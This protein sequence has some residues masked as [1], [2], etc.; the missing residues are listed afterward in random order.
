MSEHDGRTAWVR[1]YR[2]RATQ[3]GTLL[4]AIEW[5]QLSQRLAA[6]NITLT[7]EQ[8]ATWASR[9]YLPDEATPLIRSGVTPEMGGEMERHMEERAGGPEA[10]LR[11]QLIEMA[12]QGM[13]DDVD[14][15]D[16]GR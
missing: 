10:H 15:D 13:L 5:H 14:R 11:R 1:T 16:R 12:E 4:L 8:A 3:L 6:E 9:G 7:A 2:Q